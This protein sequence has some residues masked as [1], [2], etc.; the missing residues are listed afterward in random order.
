MSYNIDNN[1]TPWERIIRAADRGTG[2]R[3]SASE[4][5]SLGMDGAIA[6]KASNDAEERVPCE[7][8]YPIP[9]HRRRNGASV[10]PRVKHV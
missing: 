3:L 2:L 9:E 8:G 1:W 4:I 7:C 10:C 5:Q 6:Q